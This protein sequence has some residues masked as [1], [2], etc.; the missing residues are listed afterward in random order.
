MEQA[1]PS[2][3]NAPIFNIEQN[4]QDKAFGFPCRFS[5]LT[6]PTVGDVLRYFFY[7]YNST[8]TEKKESVSLNTFTLSI[9]NELDQLW[10]RTSIPIIQHYSIVNKL[11]KLIN[12]YRDVKK[13]K[14][15]TEYQ[16][17]IKTKD[18]LFDIAKCRC[19]IRMLKC[20]CS[21]LDQI[22]RCEKEFILDQRGAR[23]LRLQ[24]LIQT[25]HSFIAETVTSSTENATET[26]VGSEYIPSGDASEAET[27]PATKRKYTTGYYYPQLVTEADRYGISDRATA[28]IATAVLK[29]LD[30]KDDKEEPIII[31]RLKV[32]RD[33]EKNR[34]EVLR[35]NQDL[36]LLKGFS[37]DGRKDKSFDTFTQ[38]NKVHPRIITENHI[39]ILKE[40]NSVYL[41]YV[42]PGNNS[43]AEDT[44]NTL[45][46][47]FNIKNI[48][49]AHLIAVSCD[50]EPKNTGTTNGILRNLE[51]KLKR[52]LHWFVCLLHLNELPFKHLFSHLEGVT[53]GP[54][55]HTGT[56][57]KQIE[58]CETLEVS[59]NFVPIQLEH[60]PPKVESWQLSTDEKYLFE[61]ATAISTG[62]CTVDLAHRKPGRINNAR[63][64]TKASRILRLYIATE[65]PSRKLN[66]LATYIMRV[67]V[68]MYFNIKY[69]SSAVYG[70]V[71]FS[72]FIIYSQYLP[73]DLLPLIQ[74]VFKNNS[75]FAHPENI[76]LSMLF[77]ERPNVR[78]LGCEKILN[79]RESGD[80]IEKVREYQRPVINF[81]CNDYIDMIDWNKVDNLTEPPFTRNWSYDD[82][83]NYKTSNC[84]AE[85]LN[86]PCHIQATER[87]VKVVTETSLAVSAPRREGVIITKIQ[88]RKE[89]PNTDSK[90]DFQ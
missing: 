51:V 58:N 81:E 29:D 79:A 5:G 40:P 49:L 67:Y 32:R 75:Y 90:K 18:Y 43:T 23:R 87:H 36:T 88:S 44:S 45:I 61:I 35:N 38:D 17:F 78:R 28:A 84:I 63:W 14:Q 59:Q 13:H 33:R 16:E 83:M 2:K 31:D 48:S 89:R 53:T 12:R 77:D 68:P 62:S 1:G 73:K 66:I 19:D 86:I 4:I 85:D 60:M 41:G 30:V 42:S 9:A 82:I 21:L 57:S 25:E 37:F 11:N 34:Q 71:H 24:E 15:R 80:E 8:F 65:N 6:L 52:P 39:V 27:E 47:F 64:L 3:S 54:H 50:G 72:K 22:P 74:N 55:T 76:I 7:L 56:I 70:S 26:G 69:K 20:T 46:Q 10:K